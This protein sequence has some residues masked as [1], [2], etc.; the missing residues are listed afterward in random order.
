[1]GLSTDSDDKLHTVYGNISQAGSKLNSSKGLAN[2]CTTCS[3]VS[4]VKHQSGF[5]LVPG[6]LG[7]LTWRQ[8]R[9]LPLYA[10][11][12]TITSHKSEL[13]EEVGLGYI[14]A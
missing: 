9:I 11:S 5:L 6:P 12:S 4:G 7:C 13:L 2:S 14:R 10:N 1:M 3:C 8:H